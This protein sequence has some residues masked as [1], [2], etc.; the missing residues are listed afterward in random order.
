M[1]YQNFYFQ[2]IT[3]DTPVSAKDI[4]DTVPTFG[5][6]ARRKQFSSCDVLTR[7]KNG[8]NMTETIIQIPIQKD[9]KL[10]FQINT[11]RIILLN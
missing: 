2:R 5:D 11:Y 1:S 8:T 3:M 9:L 10:Y 6:T 7:A 4:G